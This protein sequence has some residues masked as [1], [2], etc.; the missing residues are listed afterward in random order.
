MLRRALRPFLHQLPK[1]GSHLCLGVEVEGAGVGHRVP[2][3]L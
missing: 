1:D 3:L 2:L